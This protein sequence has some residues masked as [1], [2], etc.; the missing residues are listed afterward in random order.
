[1][2]TVAKKVRKK[3]TTVMK[4]KKMEMVHKSV[5]RDRETTTMMM[6]KRVRRTPEMVETLRKGRRMMC[7]KTG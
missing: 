5:V 2:I 6:M 7:E 4:P 1:M 3:M